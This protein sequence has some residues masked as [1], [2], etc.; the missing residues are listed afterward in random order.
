VTGT[1][2]LGAS[3]NQSLN[4]DLSE[5]GTWSIELLGLDLDNLFANTLGLSLDPFVYYLVGVNCG[6]PTS[7]S[8]N[9]IGC[10]ANNGRNFSLASFPLFSTDPFALEF[11]TIDTSAFLVEVVAPTGAADEP[12]ALGAVLAGLAGFALMRRRVD[13]RAAAPRKRA[14]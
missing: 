4:L 7:G 12:A 3:A 1:L 8:D 10:I 11:N 6:S 5:V 9:G 2:S 13:T 14:G